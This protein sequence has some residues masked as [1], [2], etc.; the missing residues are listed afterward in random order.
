MN[1]LILS[2]T[3]LFF[4]AS[5][6][7]KDEPVTPTDPGTTY[8]RMTAGSSFTFDRYETDSTGATLSGV[9]TTVLDRVLQTDLAYQGKNGVCMIEDSSSSGIDTM[10]IAYETNNDIAMEMQLTDVGLPPLWVKIPVASGGNAVSAVSTSV[11]ISPGIMATVSDSI[12]VSLVGTENMTVKGNSIAV[13]KMNMSMHILATSAGIPLMDMTVQY[14]IYY[15]PSL[16]F[17]SKIEIPARPDLA[18]G[19]VNGERLELVDYNLK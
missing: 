2:L 3:L 16:G 12:T 19:W 18:G 8:A 6:S 14:Y 7:E 11:E 1:H 15:A 10:Y 17:Y 5:C 13:K 4:L 9:I